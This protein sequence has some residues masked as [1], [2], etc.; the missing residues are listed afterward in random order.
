M[1]SMYAHD[2]LS[3]TC[4]FKPHGTR[5]ERENCLAWEWATEERQRAEIERG[6]CRKRRIRIFGEEPDCRLQG[7]DWCAECALRLGRCRMIP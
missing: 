3:F 2:V 7:T 6:E 1:D 5:C 4:P